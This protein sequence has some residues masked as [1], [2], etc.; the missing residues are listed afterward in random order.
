VV[1]GIV[2][3]L[4]DKDLA[5]PVKAVR[6]G[7]A[8]KAPKLLKRAEPVYPPLGIQARISALIILE[9]TVDASG[10]VAAVTVLRGQPLFDD[11]AV[12]AVK[13]WVYKPLLLNG[14]PTPFVL[15]VTVNFHL[16]NATPARPES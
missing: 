13:Q 15:T 8:L 3:G 12:D 11:A 2:G 9:A 14:V 1:G 4:P 16:A 5:P 7:G 6:V 10:H